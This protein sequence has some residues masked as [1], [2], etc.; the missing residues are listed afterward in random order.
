MPPLAQVAGSGHPLWTAAT[1]TVVFTG[2]AR[3]LRGVSSSGAIA[4]AVVCFLLYWGGGPG[5]F[6][7]LGMVFALTWTAT[8]LGYQRK[9]QLG[10]AEK[11]EGRKASQVLANLSVAAASA[12]FC[13]R[14]PHR[15][16][17]LLGAVAAL[18]EAAA[19]TVSSEI[20]QA[21]GP[22]PRLITNWRQVPAGT[23]GGVSLLGTLTGVAAATIVSL[24]AAVFG[25]MPWR[26]LG[27][28]ILSATFGTLGDSILGALLER[29]RWLNNDA[30]NFLSTWVA[31]LAAILVVSF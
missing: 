6:A 29:R 31:A 26:W 4:G 10:L 22:Q 16:V 23:D 19:D 21:A 30:V 9:L 11:R 28:S 2:L 12:A 13:A 8:R 24:V 25:T 14:N 7:S 18:S 20:G 15:V 17:L 27:V 3:W 1:L 5:A